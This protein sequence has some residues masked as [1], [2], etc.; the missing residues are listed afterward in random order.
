MFLSLRLL[1]I[2]SAELCL[3]RRYTRAYLLLG[4]LYRVDHLSLSLLPYM[5][6][7]DLY[8]VACVRDQT[9]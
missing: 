8:C 2:F 7:A 3:Q 5:N 4:R 1:L 9:V 6:A